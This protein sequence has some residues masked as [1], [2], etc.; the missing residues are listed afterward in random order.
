VKHIKKAG[1]THSSGVLEIIH[2]DICDPFNVRSVE[3]FNL[4][5]TFMADFSRYGYIYRIHERSE[6]FDKFK[7][8]KAEVKNQHNVKIKT[9]RSDQGREYYRRHT[10]YGQI[11]D[12]FANLLEESVIAAQYSLPY[13]PKQNGIAK[14]W[15]VIPHSE[16]EGMKPPYVCPEC[17]NHTSS[18]NIITRFHVQ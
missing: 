2:A 13:E 1:A 14:R 12:P 15:N 6:V 5:I 17:S 11:L 4:F 8:F 16:R 10:P 18:N 7:I 9:V 3:S